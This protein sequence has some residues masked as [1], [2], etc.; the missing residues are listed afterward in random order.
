MKILL[1]LAAVAL[2]GPA[3]AEIRSATAAGFESVNVVTVAAPPARV[4]ALLVQPKLWWNGAHTYSGDATNMTLAPTAG[5]CFCETVPADGSTIEHG[6][7]VY[8]QPGKA[9]RL[10]A[11]LGPLQAEGVAAALT[12]TL[13]PAG[14][15]TEITQTYVVGGFVRGGAESFAGPVDMVVGEQLR[16]LKAQLD[17]K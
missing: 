15:G 5:G 1:A 13:K 14:T 17:A 3:A 11:A 8:A 7:V 2:A 6:R 10:H 16:R 4:Y 12:W 9:L